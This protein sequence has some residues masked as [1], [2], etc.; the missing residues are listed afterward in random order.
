MARRRQFAALAI[1]VL[2][3]FY[4]IYRNNRSPEIA[5]VVSQAAESFR[6]ISVENPALR[7]DL[8]ERLRKSQY[9][10]SHRNIFSLSAPQ[11]A[12]QAKAAPPPLPV[13][14]VAPP[15]PQ[16]QSLVVPATFYGYVTDAQTGT[17]RAFFTEGDNVYVLAIGEVLLGRFR[18]LQIGNTTADLEEVGSGRRATLT[19]EP[20][21]NSL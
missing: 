15:P 14:P 12:P 21:P 4:V 17:R 10:G 19:M 11:P 20:P 1:L 9:E 6:P 13:A 3:F 16:E 5:P 2:V 7:L 18:L 8:L